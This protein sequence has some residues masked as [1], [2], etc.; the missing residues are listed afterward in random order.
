MIEIRSCTPSWMCLKHNL[1]GEFA[2]SP[3]FLLCFYQ[4]LSYSLLKS[5]CLSFPFPFTLISCIPPAILCCSILSTWQFHLSLVFVSSRSSL[6]SPY[7]FPEY[8]IQIRLFGAYLIVVLS[9]G[10][11][12]VFRLPSVRCSLSALEGHRQ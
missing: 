10:E 1:S 8:Y 4:V 6:Q 7:C 5:I 2:H 11:S 3:L 12:G 9:G